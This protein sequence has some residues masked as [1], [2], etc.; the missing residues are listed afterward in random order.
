[1]LSHLAAFDAMGFQGALKQTLQ[2]GSKV[3]ELI[4]PKLERHLW[5]RDWQ[6]DSSLAEAETGSIWASAVA[7]DLVEA[8]TNKLRFET[9]RRQEY[10]PLAFGSTYQWI[11]DRQPKKS[12]EGLPL[13]HSFP[14]WLESTSDSVYWISGKPGSGKSVMMK[15]IAEQ[16][17]TLTHLQRWSDPL[18]VI[19]LSYFA[20]KPGDSLQS[21]SE[22]LKRAVLHQAVCQ[23]PEI[24]SLISPRRWA[25]ANAL[26]Y[27]QRF[28]DWE[29]WEVDE[30][31]DLL[32]RSCG[33]TFKL[34]MFIDGLNEFGIDPEEVLKVIKYISP[35]DPEFLKLCVASRPWV[36]FDVVFSN[37]PQLRMERLTKDDISTF[38]ADVLHEYDHFRE[39][40]RIYPNLTQGLMKEI[41]AKSRGIFLWVSL[42]VRSLSESLINRDNFQELHA[43]LYSLPSDIS[44]FYDLIWERTDPFYRRDGSWMIQIVAAAQNPLGALTLWL[45]DESRAKRVDVTELPNEIRRS[46]PIMLKRR[47]ESRT[48]GI[49]ELTQSDS[50]NYD[51]VDFSHPTARDWAQQSE[52]WKRICASYGEDFDPYIVLFEA[53]T[54]TSLMPDRRE[55]LA[56][57]RSLWYASQSCE[58]NTDT[59]RLVKLMESFD[60]TMQKYEE[61]ELHWSHNQCFNIPSMTL[62][63]P[64]EGPVDGTTEDTATGTARSTAWSV[65][66]GTAENTAPTTIDATAPKPLQLLYMFGLSQLLSYL[67]PAE[68]QLDSEDQYRQSPIDLMMRSK[69]RGTTLNAVEEAD[70]TSES[71]TVYTQVSTDS[72]RHRTDS[73]GTDL[74]AQLYRDLGASRKEDIARVSE[75]LPR[76]LQLFAFKIGK[77]GQSRDYQDIVHFIHRYRSSGNIS[78]LII[79]IY[80]GLTSHLA[81][82]PIISSMKLRNGQLFQ[83]LA[84]QKRRQ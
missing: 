12:P 15:Y 19:L 31:F 59:A 35:T 46:A 70:D 49:L 69:H 11:F 81:P 47:L 16:T 39:I 25:L 80:Y 29:N 34:A 55:P 52:T 76:I 26:P 42:V 41:V 79:L 36:Q 7:G 57:K 68:L 40:L 28:P 13:W 43:R 82:L 73:Y 83:N 30:S 74:A 9:D 2:T 24:I 21:S 72:T 63:G 44:D 32:L 50:G 38:V 45:A 14:D 1:M 64:V 23:Q 75:A 51:V 48:G 17:G 66:E 5:R 4:Y 71:G 6:P 78:G 20:W 60:E 61:G 77:E 54:L 8:M 22:G 37:V 58:R 84:Y 33:Q 10:I 18:P 56:T 65:A 27:S 53:E 3:V 62:R 67:D